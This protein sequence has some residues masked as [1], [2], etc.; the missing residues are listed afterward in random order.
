[1]RGKGMQ[2]DNSSRI[3]TV[4]SASQVDIAPNTLPQRETGSRAA[5][6]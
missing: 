1:M 6:P 2:Y 5:Q 4:E 3:L